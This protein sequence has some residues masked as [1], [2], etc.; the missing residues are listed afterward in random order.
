MVRGWK[1]HLYGGD[2]SETEIEC[3]YNCIKY[4]YKY[5]H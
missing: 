3:K 4:K 1:E 5:K 2:M